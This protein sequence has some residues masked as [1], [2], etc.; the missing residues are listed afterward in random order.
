MDGFRVNDSFALCGERWSG[1]AGCVVD[2]DTIV[3]GNGATRRRIRFTG[4]DA[5]EL[6]GACL[7]ER[8]RAQDARMALHQWLAKGAFEWSGDTDPLRDQYGRELREAR[9]ARAD[10]GYTYLAATMIG[11]DLAL[12]N[13]WPSPQVDWCR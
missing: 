9:R 13:D 12:Q 5:P 1:A 8:A 6:D 11:R 7:A 10:G 2:G 3:I 4:F